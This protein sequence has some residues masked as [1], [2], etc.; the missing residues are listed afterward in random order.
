MQITRRTSIVP[1]LM[2]FAVLLEGL[3][4]AQ[5][6]SFTT[7]AG[8][9]GPGAL[10]EIVVPTGPWNG[11]LVVFAQ[12]IG[13]PSDPIDLPSV[14]TL[15]QTFTSQG[16]ALVYTSRSV[17]GYGA[18][19]DGMQRTHQLRGVFAETIGQ[20]TRVYLMG[21]SL[22]GLIAVMLAERFPGQ[23]DGVLSGCGLLGGGGE[24]LKY[25]GD[26]RLLF[27]YFFPGVIHGTPFDVPPY[28]H[29][30][31]GDPTYES[32]R[33]ALL[34][35]LVSPGQPTL[36]FARAANLQAAN[37]SEIVAAGLQTVG[38][39]LIQAND[40]IDVTH[41]HM[42]YDNSQTWYSGSEDDDA[43]NA[44]VARYVSDPSASNYMDHYDTPTGT[45]RIPVL[46]LH[47]ARDPLVPILHEAMYAAA[48]QSAGASEYL[49]QRTV[50]GFGHCGFPAAETAAFSALV[51]WVETGVR[52][53]N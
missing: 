44:G 23:Y 28:I 49:L 30:A 19:K 10:Y 29:F 34:Q 8:E 47:K 1:A 9:I 31:P 37:D 7:I 27:D 24:E 35:G 46:T 22:G 42:P 14:G 11:E 5:S 50:D 32:V 48:V 13:Q 41:G 12:G 52:P 16:F 3:P 18:V 20:P 38:F 40:L 45:L 43:L 21:R 6:P 36:Q 2:A 25:V 26:A 15:R 51:Q 17:N 39:T 53:Q 33:N 4:A